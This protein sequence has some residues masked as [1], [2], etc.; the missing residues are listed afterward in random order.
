MTQG[1]V[2]RHLIVFAFPLLLGNLFQQLYNTVD[3]WIVG[4][5]VGN[6][7]FAAV[8]T[9]GG[10][11]NLLIYAFNGLSTGVGVLNLITT[12]VFA[13]GILLGRRVWKIPLRGNGF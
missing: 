7:A 8:G 12:A 2:V 10:I 9:V 6:E 11:T 3:A 13:G 4:N 5:Y 1:S